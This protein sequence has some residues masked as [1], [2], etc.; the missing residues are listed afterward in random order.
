MNL[1]ELEAMAGHPDH[2]AMF[3]VCRRDGEVV[4]WGHD[5]LDPAEGAEA[6]RRVAAA[7]S[8]KYPGGDV[9][10]GW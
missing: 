10:D 4:V 3:I 5:D 6:L 8:I 7:M 1:A 2:W 9:P